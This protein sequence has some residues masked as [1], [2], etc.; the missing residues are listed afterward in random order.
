[1]SLRRMQTERVNIDET[2]TAFSFFFLELHKNNL[3]N[4]FLENLNLFLLFLI[5]QE[6]FKKGKFKN[7]FNFLKLF[8]L[9]L[10]FNLIGIKKAF[11]HSDLLILKKTARELTKVHQN[12]HIAY[13][14]NSIL[15]T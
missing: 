14:A 9:F 10:L 6:K 12:V 1:M 11:L 13:S 5:L 8:I 7:T 4:F 2:L 15:Y 3:R